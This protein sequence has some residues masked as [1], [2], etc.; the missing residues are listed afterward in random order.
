MTRA[1]FALV[2][3]LLWPASAAVAGGWA[4]T[5]LDELPL[6]GYEVGRTYRIGYTVK[7]HGTWPIDLVPMGGTRVVADR[8]DVKELPLA[9]E[10]RPDGPLG[11]YVAEVR[12]PTAGEWDLRVSQGP[13]PTQPIGRVVAFAPQ[14][15]AS[16]PAMP[17]TPSP[18][19]RLPGFLAPTMVGATAAL[20]VGLLY[21]LR[22][23]ERLA[24]R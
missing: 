6:K 22:R 10:G 1:L 21:A 12:F 24:A 14:S 23:D 18:T 4:V 19:L 20:L 9:F 11:H 2:L 8:L 3:L 15:P 7:L 13:W 5:T 17:M 16:A